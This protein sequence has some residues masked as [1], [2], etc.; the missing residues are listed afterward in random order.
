MNNFSNINF[1]SDPELF[2]YDSKNNEIVSAIGLIPG[3]K[4][5]PFVINKDGYALQTDNVLAEF[6]IPVC[7][8]EDEFVRHMNFMK[9][10]IRKYVKEKNENYDL[11]HVADGRLEEKYLK[12]PQAQE[13]GCSEDYNAWLEGDVNP[14]P[15]SF[16]SNLRSVGLHLH[17]GYDDPVAPFNVLL[18]KF[19]D[20][21]LGVPSVLIEPKNERRTLYGQAGS[22]RH[23]KY[24]L[25][26][27]VLSGYFLKDD[28]LLRW[29]I[30]NAWSAIKECDKYLSKEAG[31][32][33][34]DSLK[35]RIITAIKGDAKEADSLVKEYGILLP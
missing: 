4:E 1:G 26:Y 27:R 24:G 15:K 17:C 11:L 9:D 32:I 5:D 14:K 13:I 19:L 12:D 3:T 8:N 20:L 30:R 6:N 31:A 18:V 23:C 21:F 16:S 25:E 22:F 34:I 10:Y 35:D 28:S 7:T 2:I 33:D 29:I